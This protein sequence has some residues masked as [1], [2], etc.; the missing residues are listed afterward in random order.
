MHIA[1]ISYWNTLSLKS[2]QTSTHSENNRWSLNIIFFVSE[3]H[4]NYDYNYK[5]LLLP[6]YEHIIHT[7][8]LQ[9]WIWM[10]CYEYYNQ[11][12]T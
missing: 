10:L 1:V 4:F 11:N 6:T 2:A 5:W 7:N 12:M 3:G 8:P 9:G